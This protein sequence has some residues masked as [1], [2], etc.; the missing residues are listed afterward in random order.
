LARLARHARLDLLDWLDKVE[1]V[2]SSRVESG[3]SAVCHKTTVSTNC[4][5]T[6]YFR[7]ATL[8]LMLIHV[9]SGGAFL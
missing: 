6:V 9:S 7:C 5:V 3:N 4:T 2:E 1:R 8:D